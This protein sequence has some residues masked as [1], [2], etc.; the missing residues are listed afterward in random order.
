MLEP[1]IGSA[2]NID[3]EGGMEYQLKEISIK[4]TYHVQ[5]SYV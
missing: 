5:S 2:T 1:E 4:K 3:S